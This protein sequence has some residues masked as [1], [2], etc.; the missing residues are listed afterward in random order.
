MYR[1]GWVIFRRPTRRAT[2]EVGTADSAE[3]FFLLETG[4]TLGVDV[5]LKASCSITVGSEE[6]SDDV[7]IEKDTVAEF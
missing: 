3:D 4:E 5:I 1:L 7:D 6:V 2:G